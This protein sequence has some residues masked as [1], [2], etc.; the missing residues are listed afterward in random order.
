MTRYKL[1]AEVKPPL[2]VEIVVRRK[3]TYVGN[4]SKVVTLDSNQ[5]SDV[6]W[7]VDDLLHYRYLDWCFVDEDEEMAFNLNGEDNE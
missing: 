5:T 3:N 2:D 6:D 4:N 7:H 1:L